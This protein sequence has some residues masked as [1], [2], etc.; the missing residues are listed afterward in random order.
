MIKYIVVKFQDGHVLRR[1]VPL[2][3]DLMTSV[4]ATAV[5]GDEQ[6]FLSV[7]LNNEYIV[8]APMGEIKYFY[9]QKEEG[10]KE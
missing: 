6:D 8:L 2:S 5:G 9:I 7:K 3:G 1:E 4:C 10:N